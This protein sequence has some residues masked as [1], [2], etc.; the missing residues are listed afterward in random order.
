MSSQVLRSIDVQNTSDMLSFFF[1]E[2]IKCYEKRQKSSKSSKSQTHS[3]NH[4]FMILG[5]NGSRR[6]AA[7]HGRAMHLNR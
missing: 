4:K 2:I 7:L 3:Q 5:E 1:V 6:N